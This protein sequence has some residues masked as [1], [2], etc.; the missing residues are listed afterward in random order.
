MCIR[1]GIY[2][3][4]KTENNALIQ[5]TYWTTQLNDPELINDLKDKYS[6][7]TFKAEQA[8]ASSS[9]LLILLEWILPLVIFWFLMMFIVRKATGGKGGAGGV[10]GV[11]KSLSLIHI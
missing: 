3:T 5:T 4:P 1:D 8:S 11:G 6:G 7:V 9:I 10:F 2:I